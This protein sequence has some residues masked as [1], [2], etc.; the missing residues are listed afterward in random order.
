MFLSWICLFG[1]YDEEKNN[2]MSFFYRFDNISYDN[3]VI[4]IL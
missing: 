2:F 4:L 3:C 1:K